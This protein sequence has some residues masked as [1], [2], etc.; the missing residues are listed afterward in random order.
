MWF[1]QILY[2][3]NVCVSIMKTNNNVYYI[4]NKMK[5]YVCNV[6]C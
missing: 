2:H 1:L 5:I 3:W 4:I 6:E